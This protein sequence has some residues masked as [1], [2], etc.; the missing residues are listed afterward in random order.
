M[1]FRVFDLKEEKWLKENIYM[2]AD[3]EMFL[4]KQSLFGFSKVPLALSPDR[5]ICHMTINLWDKNSVEIYEGDFIKAQVEE[6][7]FV[8]GIVAFAQELS[9]YIILCE[10]SNEFY[11]LG[12]DVCEY[13]EK[14]GNVFDGYEESNEDD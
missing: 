3:G 7:K 11:T 10:D 4:I 8:I 2:N 1:G 5:Y 12:K 6:D 14:I 13:I 9:A